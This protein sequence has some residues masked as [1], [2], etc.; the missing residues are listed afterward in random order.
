MASKKAFISG[1]PDN[2]NWLLWD[3]VKSFNVWAG[4]CLCVCVCVCHWW[5]KRVRDA[6]CKWEMTVWDMTAPSQFYPIRIFYVQ[7]GSWIMQRQ[8]K[9]CHRCRTSSVF[10]IDMHVVLPWTWVCLLWGEV[11]AWSLLLFCGLWNWETCTPRLDSEI[12]NI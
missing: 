1:A 11:S 4:V 5:W 10:V 12:K 9:W 7:T 8:V 6:V 2:A 3:P